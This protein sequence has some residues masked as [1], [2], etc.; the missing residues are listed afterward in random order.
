[1]MFQPDYVALRGRDIGHG[2]QVYVAG[3]DEAITEKVRCHKIFT[4]GPCVK[5]VECARNMHSTQLH[6]KIACQIIHQSSSDGCFAHLPRRHIE[7][8]EQITWGPKK[9]VRRKSNIQPI[10]AVV[11]IFNIVPQV[12]VGIQMLTQG[13][14][15]WC[16]Q[17]KHMKNTAY[18]YINTVVLHSHYHQ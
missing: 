12:S 7:Y 6:K 13:I 3:S 10:R 9:A 1:M 4:G 5:S 16:D 14:C 8:W 11:T 17:Q 2:F 15:P 18:S